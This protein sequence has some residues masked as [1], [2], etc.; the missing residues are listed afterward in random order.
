MNRKGYTLIELMITVAIIGIVASTVLGKG[1]SMGDG[2][3]VGVVAKLSHRGLAFETWEGQMII[4]GQGTVTTNLW[5]FSIPDP[6]VVKEIQ[7]ALD[8][9]K[10]VKL[11]YHQVLVPLPWRGST[12]Y[13]IKKVSPLE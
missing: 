9:Q 11:A 13:Y 4:G 8:S 12:S 2:E 5:D 3:R 10:K 1:C 6:A 7:A